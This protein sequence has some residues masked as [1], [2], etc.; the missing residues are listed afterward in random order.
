[1]R[2]LKRVFAILLVIFAVSALFLPSSVGNIEQ[3]LAN[4]DFSALKSKLVTFVS[5]IGTVPILTHYETLSA[6]ITALLD[7]SVPWW[8]FWEKGDEAVNFIY[9]V[10]IG[11]ILA[12]GTSVLD[13]VEA[14]GNL[15]G[16]TFQIPTSADAV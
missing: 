2:T 15:F 14:L 7:P 10:T 11:T 16:F 1:M 13:V 5:A 9:D 12:V 8:K 6:D 4:L 3:T